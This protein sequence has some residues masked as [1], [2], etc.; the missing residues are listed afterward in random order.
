MQVFNNFISNKAVFRVLTPEQFA[1]ADRFYR[2]QG[3]KLKCA[4][5]ERV[6]VLVDEQAD[7]IAAVRLLPQASGHFWLRN[8]L[9]VKAWRGRGL[10]KHILRS[11]LRDIAPQGCYFFALPH[12]TEFYLALDFTID[13][14]HCPDDIL[15]LHQTYRARGRDWVLMGYCPV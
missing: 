4:V 10:A 14:E 12:L 6:Y 8:L 11:L 9:V 1:L 13:P 3:Y 7:F 15:R 5:T 2:A